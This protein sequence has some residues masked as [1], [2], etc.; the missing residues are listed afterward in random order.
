MALDGELKQIKRE[1]E[2]CLE[3]DNE[4]RIPLWSKEFNV[5]EDA[6]QF[7]G[8]AIDSLT[9]KAMAFLPVIWETKK[10]NSLYNLSGESKLFM[11]ALI[12]GLECLADGSRYYSDYTNRLIHL[13][14][15]GGSVVHLS[16]LCQRTYKEIIIEGLN[17]GPQLEI[18]IYDKAL[19]KSFQ[20]LRCIDS[21]HD[22]Q[23]PFEKKRDSHKNLGQA[24][25]GVLF[26]LTTYYVLSNILPESLD[27]AATIGGILAYFAGFRLGG[28][29]GE[30]RGRSE[31]NE[32]LSEI[33]AQEFSHFRKGYVQEL[34]GL[35]TS[36][37]VKK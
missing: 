20:I 35:E 4:K 23:E 5:A 19:D 22:L 37:M 21:R 32:Q 17:P 12:S 36:I 29:A 6:E 24:L 11:R 7:Y 16:A 26:G 25:G 8:G 28:E 14:E 3:H 15:E 31:N 1:V 34:M 18:P 10:S 9:D 27:M 30:L 33:F 2:Y 13:L